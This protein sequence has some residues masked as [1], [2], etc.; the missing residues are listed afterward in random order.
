MSLVAFGIRIA[1]VRAIRAVIWPEFTVADSPQKPLALLADGKPLIAVYTGHDTDKMD[2]RELY[3]GDPKVAL[4]IQIFLPAQ[5]TVTVAGKP[6]KLDTREEG[7]ETLLDVIARRILGAFLAQDEPWSCLWAELVQKTGR[8]QNISYLVE[9]TDVRVSAR[10]VSLD[11]EVLYEPMPGA[12]PEGVWAR[13]IALMRADVGLRSVA[14]LADWIAGEIAGPKTLT[15]ADR[16]RIDLGLSR[17][18]AEAIGIL[19]LPDSDGAALKQVTVTQPG[20]AEPRVVVAS[21]TQTGPTPL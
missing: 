19:P 15:Q 20:E 6:L 21:A 1:T 18:A 10:E 8:S 12:P 13:L 7:A 2:G 11:C 3:S 17:Y 14:P 5:V 9:T 4:A 16:D